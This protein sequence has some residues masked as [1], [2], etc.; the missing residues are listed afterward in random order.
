MEL[1]NLAWHRTEIAR[2]VNFKTGE[3]DQDF[4]GPANAPWEKIDA[5]FNEA[6]TLE[7]N[8]ALQEG[9][10]S[11]FL[12]TQQFTWAASAV[13]FTLPSYI[14]RESIHS[15]YDVTSD[16]SGIPMNVTPRAANRKIWWL[17]N[18]TL[19]WSTTGPGSAATIEIVYLREAAPLTE[20]TQE[21]II[22]Y[23]HRHLLNWSAAVI[24]IETADQKAPDSW[25]V[26]LAEYREIFHLALSRGSPAETN[27]ARIRNHR[28]WR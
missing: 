28:A 19:Q 8:F 12:A 6:Q 18:T 20:P 11:S 1:R 13:T 16:S 24:L 27:V 2:I 4:A 5:A 7:R 15:M 23:N 10:Y 3:P 25:L 17:N 9:N 26:R 14:D 22:P 21:S